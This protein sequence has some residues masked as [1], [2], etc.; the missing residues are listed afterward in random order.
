[1]VIPSAC[2]EEESTGHERSASTNSLAYT[3]PVGRLQG[4][5]D[6]GSDGQFS[7][8]VPIDLPAG[9]A[10]YTPAVALSYSSTS[11]TGVAGVGFGL[12]A[13][14]VITRCARTEAVDGF[15]A[16]PSY[17]ADDAFCLDGARLVPEAPGSHVYRTSTESHL[18]ATAHMEG[19]VTGGPASW[20]VQFPNGTVSHFGRKADLNSRAYLSSG[21][22]VAY[23][24]ESDSDDSFG[25]LI[26][27]R[28]DPP[29]YPA[30]TEETL[31]R[32]LLRRIH[33]G[34][35]L[36][37]SPH[38][39]EVRFS[40]DAGPYPVRTGYER[41]YEW[42]HNGV[43][44]EITVHPFEDPSP[45]S[46]YLLKYSAAGST[47]NPRMTSIQHCVKAPGDHDP[48]DPPGNVCMRPTE[49]EWRTG[50]SAGPSFEEHSR[51]WEMDIDRTYVPMMTTGP[52][53]GERFSTVA[54]LDFDG[55]GIDDLLYVDEDRVHVRLGHSDAARALSAVVDTSLSGAD[56][57]YSIGKQYLVRDHDGDGRD[58]LLTMRAVDVDDDDLYDEVHLVWHQSTGTDFVS[59]DLG[60][61]GPLSDAN[62]WGI[63]TYIHNLWKW[64]PPESGERLIYAAATRGA[65][66]TDFHESSR[67]FANDFTGDGMTDIISCQVIA[68]AECAYLPTASARLPGCL[69]EWTVMRSDEATFPSAIGAPQST[70][71]ETVCRLQN[72]P[73]FTSSVGD[74]TGDGIP[75]LMFVQSGVRPTAEEGSDQL[76][77]G[78]YNVL[79]YDSELDQFVVVDTGLDPA[80]LLYPS[81]LDVNGD[82]APDVVGYRRSV[83]STIERMALADIWGGRRD[84]DLVLV[85]HLGRGDGTFLERAPFAPEAWSLANRQVR[86][87]KQMAFCTDG[88]FTCEDPR[89]S[90]VYRPSQPIDISGD[91]RVEL[92]LD[93]LPS[94][95]L[96]SY[97]E[98]DNSVWHWDTA[99]VSVASW[100]GASADP[101]PEAG[102]G[103]LSQ[104]IRIHGT[105]GGGTIPFT[106]GVPL[107]DQ[108]TRA[109]DFDGDGQEDYVRYELPSHD[110]P[111]SGTYLDGQLTLFENV[112]S[113]YEIIERVKDGIGQEITVEYSE[114]SDADV[115]SS[116]HA[117]YYPQRCWRGDAPLVSSLTVGL[118]A[119]R[120]LT[121]YSYADGREDVRGRGF[122]GFAKTSVRNWASGAVITR[123]FD[124]VTVSEGH[125]YA[126]A[127][128]PIMEVTADTDAGSSATTPPS[129][130]TVGS[131]RYVAN[132]VH[133]HESTAGLRRHSVVKVSET[134]SYY[135]DLA[136]RAESEL[137][138]P[139]VFSGLTPV[140]GYTAIS[141]YEA[142]RADPTVWD[143]ASRVETSYIGGSSSELR[144]EHLPASW[145]NRWRAGRPSFRYERA[146]KEMP[147]VRQTARKWVYD[148]LTG[149]VAALE[150]QTPHPLLT[151]S[152]AERERQFVRVEMDHDDYGN[153]VEQR[154]D[155]LLA[156]RRLSTWDYG[157]DGWRVESSSNDLDHT[158]T[159]EH[160]VRFGTQVAQTDPNGNR[161]AIVVDGFGRAVV[162]KPATGL[163]RERSFAWRT[164]DVPGL[165][166]RDDY[167]DGSFV[168]SELDEFERLI[169]DR[170]PGFDGAPRDVLRRVDYDALGRVRAVWEPIW[171]GEDWKTENRAHRFDYNSVGM[172]R[173]E[174]MPDG[175]VQEYTRG[176]GNATFE[177][178]NGH[179]YAMTF[180]PLGRVVSVTEPAGATPEF[181]QQEFSWCPDGTLASTKGPT[182]VVDWNEYDSLGRLTISHDS[183]RGTWGYLLDPFGNVEKISSPEGQVS[184][185]FDSLDRML[186][187][188]DTDGTAE[189]FYDSGSDAV[190]R[191]VETRSSDGI[192]TVF[193]Y[194]GPHLTTHELRYAD[195]TKLGFEYSFDGFGRLK[196]QTYPRGSFKTVLSYAANGILTSVQDA[197]SG[198]I[199]WEVDKLTPRG[200]VRSETL[201]DGSNTETE[202]RPGSSRVT[203]ITAF[204]S[205][206]TAILDLRYGH[207]RT[208]AVTRLEDQLHSFVETFRYDERSRMVEATSPLGALDYDYDNLGN[209]TKA[210]GV[211]SYVYGDSTRPYL[212][213]SIGGVQQYYDDA[214]R[215][216][217][218]ALGRS[219]QWT[220]LGMVRKIEDASSKVEYRYD[221]GGGRRLELTSAGHTYRFDDYELDKNGNE[222]IVIRG[223]GGIV[224]TGARAAG[225][226]EFKLLYRHTDDI[227]NARVLTNES[228]QVVEERARGPFGEEYGVSWSTAI[229]STSDP[230]NR[231]LTGHRE[232][233]GL[234]IVEMGARDY[235]VRTKRMLSPDPVSARPLSVQGR[236]PYSYVWNQPRTFVDPTG[237]TPEESAEGLDAPPAP[238]GS[239]CEERAE[240]LDPPPRGPGGHPESGAR[241][242]RPPGSPSAGEGAVRVTEPPR[243]REGDGGDSAGAPPAE[244]ER[245]A[246]ILVTSGRTLSRDST[247]FFRRTR[248]MLLRETG[249]AN[250]VGVWGPHATELARRYG[251]VEVRH[252]VFSSS[253][254]AS[255]VNALPEN[256]RIETLIII[257]HGMIEEDGTS[258]QV[259]WSGLSSLRAPGAAGDVKSALFWDAVRNRAV[260]TGPMTVRLHT[261][262][263]GADA[264]MLNSIDRAL[265]SEER[266]V[267]V[268]GY[269]GY[270]GTGFVGDRRAN[271]TFAVEVDG[272]RGPMTREFRP[273][274]LLPASAQTD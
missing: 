63:G 224:A 182:G 124:N 274:S 257:G 64:D 22:T 256:V 191:M 211:G 174:T 49:F 120:S 28:W 261:C 29:Q 212:P 104:Y 229:G 184:A 122:L 21:T 5:H 272:P 81:V 139:S 264:S 210:T 78:A 160:H 65:D 86:F 199:L 9:R 44:D 177:D 165:V 113:E 105:T 268:F 134:L 3:S 27:Y 2:G 30:S 56:E 46:T 148:P 227:G 245:I 190:G 258:G 266:S 11:Q 135:E 213:T 223:G 33:Y 77:I 26:D 94:N 269:V 109:G 252:G 131:I 34:G 222:S 144:V 133:Y 50:N 106:Y 93:T 192:A 206:G 209:M 159:Y 90:W 70:G 132:K 254:A 52:L 255:I 74:F 107:F 179:R 163:D 158:T 215:F 114:R 162:H 195:G 193:G 115:H 61:I 40:Y 119:N 118:G 142:D 155:T 67:S 71:V 23:W 80:Q 89:F 217:G 99:D 150:S 130:R 240:G 103:R 219:V 31:P 79:T 152:E 178:P 47:G 145:G 230:A 62:Y 147:C 136:P 194:D 237:M 18:I 20:T 73:G 110:Y 253:Y 181:T 19:P 248:R 8:V 76:T 53:V 54:P 170:G 154:V 197:S 236:H 129:L 242:S 243:H 32:S 4:S 241:L 198:R 151:I 59:Q 87:Q 138:T 95:R 146:G 235:D 265:T 100:K 250:E 68:D 17:G 251:N 201:G 161:D 43:L 41:G 168:V 69:G 225:D 98:E 102:S 244:L 13:A 83:D 246:L 270:Y 176:V 214:G 39:Y 267:Q 117:C 231:G 180:G 172:L 1:M 208:G 175:M 169:Y 186:T 173:R 36:D 207:D 171:E 97:E 91:G 156:P 143:R 228:G 111:D 200:L 271:G 260:E 92:V 221:A 112:R 218:D 259:A 35:H 232:P 96:F 25:N 123:Y 196:G 125:V 262:Y 141:Y 216:K 202:Y 204:D 14:S 183:S 128:S 15:I 140:R 157:A 188:T 116:S 45:F 55:D 247:P 10:G 127:R 37:G 60:R 249:S 7:Y 24:L 238:C 48:G 205:A 226:P 166:V 101:V 16:A 121:E 57:V 126:H 203:D 233:A 187:R 108:N 167:A 88:G 137:T 42:V 75:D 164:G 84:S 38:R 189:F 58:D 234:G 220:G 82:G 153:V 66:V 6:V 51:F 149:A 273:P 239:S 72:E 263:T 185:T 12:S 85:V